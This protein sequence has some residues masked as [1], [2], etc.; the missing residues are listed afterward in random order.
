M[1]LRVGIEQ[2]TLEEIPEVEEAGALEGRLRSGI[3]CA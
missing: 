1:M 2:I 3:G